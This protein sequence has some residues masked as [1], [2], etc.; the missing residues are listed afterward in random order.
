MNKNLIDK[1]RNLVHRITNE[2][3]GLK[4][5]GYALAYCNAMTMCTTKEEVYTQLIYI[6][7]NLQFWKGETARALKKELKALISEMRKN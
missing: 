4:N 7:C 5:S 6:S 1:S 2:I 3:T